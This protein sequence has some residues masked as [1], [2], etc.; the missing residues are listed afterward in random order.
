MLNDLFDVPNGFESVVNFELELQRLHNSDF[1]VVYSLNVEALALFFGLYF[2]KDPRQC[3]VLLLHLRCQENADHGD[4]VGVEL[5][6]R[7]SEVEPP[8]KRS[9]CKPHF[10]V[11][12]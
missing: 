4:V 8:E 11:K 7:I 5:Q 6:K 9:G 10:R 2:F 12:L 1:E 3:H